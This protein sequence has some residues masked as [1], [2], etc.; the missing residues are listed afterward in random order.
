MQSCLSII[1]VMLD[2]AKQRH[3]EQLPEHGIGHALRYD[4]DSAVVVVR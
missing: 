3:D 4:S 2:E 1:L